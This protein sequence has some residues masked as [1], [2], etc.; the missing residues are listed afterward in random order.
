MRVTMG[1]NLLWNGGE[2]LH[3]MRISIELQVVPK[4]L[5]DP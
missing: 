5:E 1:S 3:S 4:L 2:T